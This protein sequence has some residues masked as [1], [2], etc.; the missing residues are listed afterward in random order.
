[1]WTLILY[2]QGDRKSTGQ[3]SE[4]LW[5]FI[6]IIAWVSSSGSYLKYKWIHPNSLNIPPA[7]F[8]PIPVPRN[9]CYW[10]LG[11]WRW[12]SVRVGQGPPSSNSWPN[13]SFY[14]VQGSGLASS[15][16]C[17]LKKSTP[18]Y[19]PPEESAGATLLC[20]SPVL[21][22]CLIHC[23]L[24][25]GN[26]PKFIL[27]NRSAHLTWVDLSKPMTVFILP[28]PITTDTV[29]LKRSLCNYVA[30]YAFQG[31]FECFIPVDPHRTFCSRHGIIIPFFFFNRC[32]NSTDRGSDFPWP[33]Q[34]G[35]RGA[36]SSI[37]I[38]DL[39]PVLWATSLSRRR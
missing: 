3:K 17:T 38:P 25:Q 21:D 15:F 37:Q 10:F 7:N 14:R 4:S 5:S 34:Q 18:F 20:P 19:Q 2:W 28:F 27:Q 26:C 11:K 33:T 13:T 32:D 31:I 8:S 36:H 30:V 24:V 22:K 23:N 9:I 29:I 39:G 35:Q 6:S 1:M 12:M 16:T